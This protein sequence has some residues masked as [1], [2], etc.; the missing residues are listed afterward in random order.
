MFDLEWRLDEV[1]QYAVW[2][3]QPHPGGADDLEAVEGLVEE[4]ERPEWHEPTT[5]P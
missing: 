3:Q 2:F 1:Q 5:L 4:L